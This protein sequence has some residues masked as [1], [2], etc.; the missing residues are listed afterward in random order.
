MLPSPS[1]TKKIANGARSSA[2]PAVATPSHALSTPSPNGASASAKPAAQPPHRCAHTLAAPGAPLSLPTTSRRS[3]TPRPTPSPASVLP[4]PTSMH[5]AYARA[6]PW[7]SSVA[8]SMPIP[9]ASSA[10][11]NRTRCSDTCMPRPFL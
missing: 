4:R 8:R 1:T 3:F 10:A 11:G 9:S 6:G 5:A 7:R 2:M